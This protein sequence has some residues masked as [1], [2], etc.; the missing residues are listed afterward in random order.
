MALRPDEVTI[1]EHGNVNPRRVPVTGVACSW[2]MSN[3]GAFSCFTT[4]RALQGAGLGYDLAGMW[5]TW[6]G[7]AGDWG[8]V[9]EGRPVS[10]GAVEI[11]AAGWAELLRGR[12]LHPL[13]RRD[14]GRVGGLAALAIT[15]S[16]AEAEAGSVI[17]LG[18]IEDGGEPVTID[19]GAQD[20]LDDFLPALVEAGGLE[21]LVDVER[22]F[23]AGRFVGRDRSHVLR[24]T[25]GRHFAAGDC[26]LAD[27]SWSKSPAELVAFESNAERVSGGGGPSTAPAFGR[28]RRTRRKTR[29]KRGGRDRW[30]PGRRQT[31]LVVDPIVTGPG[32]DGLVPWEEQ[33]AGVGMRTLWVPQP[34]HSLLETTPCEVAVRDVDHAWGE[35]QI[36]NVVRLLVGS[37]GFS[38]FFRILNRGYDAAAGVLALSG[39]ALSDRRAAL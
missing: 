31:G 11:A 38:G 8:G 26:A 36:G 6:R 19:F 24:L 4:Q 22:R 39:E 14:Q 25:E 35:C 16:D 10:G 3:P 12:A 2:E 29:R 15:G 20:V 30:R 7:V 13:L 9:I 37:A 27:S 33:P 28:R 21:W 5:L 17:T 23:H 32:D 34:P 18:V 1:A